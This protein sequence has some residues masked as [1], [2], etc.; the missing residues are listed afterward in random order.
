[1][2]SKP[3]PP[4]KVTAIGRKDHQ[5]IEP[6]GLYEIASGQVAM[7]RSATRKHC[8]HRIAFALGKPRFW[9][10]GT[11]APGSRQSIESFHC[12]AQRI[13]WARVP[14]QRNDR[15]VFMPSL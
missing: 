15:Q 10:T 2:K 6:A 13:S 3:I 4:K 14:K 9:L 1:M 7:D 12:Q 11:S 5:T 8:P